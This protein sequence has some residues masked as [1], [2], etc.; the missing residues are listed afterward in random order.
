MKHSARGNI[1]FISRPIESPARHLG[2]CSREQ[3]RLGAAFLSSDQ[4]PRAR[5]ALAIFAQAAG[6]TLLR[7]RGFKPNQTFRCRQFG[8]PGAKMRINPMRMKSIGTGFRKRPFPLPPLVRAKRPFGDVCAKIGVSPFVES[9]LSGYS[10]CPNGEN[11]PKSANHT[12]PT[13]AGI[14]AE[15]TAI[16]PPDQ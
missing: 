16:R 7:L 4:R 6:F 1:R 5:V 9:G 11:W 13:A 8:F 15:R 2:P 12:A 10:F 14:R 3:A